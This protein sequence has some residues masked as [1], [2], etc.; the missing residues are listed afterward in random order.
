[1]TATTIPVAQSNAAEQQRIANGGHQKPPL[2]DTHYLDNRIFT[3][4]GIF[5]QEQSDIFQKVWMF[6]CHES[7]IPNP[8]DFRTTKVAGKPIVIVRGED[9]A[10]RTFFNVCR[11]RGAEVVREESGNA[12]S[13]RCFYH[14]WNYGLDGALC[15]VTKPA[16]Y[17]AVKFDK[18]QFGLV[19]IRTES[20]VG[21]L[22]VCLDPEAQPLSDF[23]GEIAEPFLKPLGTVPLKVFHFHKTVLNTNWKLW[24]DNNSERYHAFVHWMNV[25][26]LPWVMG[27]TSNMRL[28]ICKNGHSGYWSDGSEVVDYGKAGYPGIADSPLPGLKVSEMR[29]VNIFPDLLIMIRSNVVRFDR[30]VPLSAGRTLLECRGI[31]V[32]DDSEE[33]HAVRLQHHNLLWGPAGRNFPEDVLAAESQWRA[34]EADAVRYSVL[35]REENLN[36]TD[37]ANLRAYYAEWGRRMGLMPSAPFDSPLRP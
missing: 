17:E 10:I 28:R 19:P 18:G 36:P 29:V 35:A 20:L 9:G 25:K 6:V 34:M 3:D 26:T 7:E 2:P 33:L 13:L 14:Q 4:E 8:G 23:L 5:R 30:L 24:Q 12:R 21:L 1:M 16:G 11:H 31:G 37:D 22:F 27:K 32:L 15:S